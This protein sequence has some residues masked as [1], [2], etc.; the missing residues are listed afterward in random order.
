MHRLR[1]GV[2]MRPERPFSGEL[3]AQ[4]RRLCRRDFVFAGQKHRLF[5]SQPGADG[6]P[7]STGGQPDI[8]VIGSPDPITWIRCKAIMLVVLVWFEVDIISAEFDR[9]VKQVTTDT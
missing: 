2:C 3:G 7:E 1:A 6:P 5:S 8:S 4:G 9:G